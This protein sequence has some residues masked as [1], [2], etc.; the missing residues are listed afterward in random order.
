MTENEIRENYGN[1]RRLIIS[2]RAWNDDELEVLD[3]RLGLHNF[4]FAHIQDEKMSLY[5]LFHQV[6]FKE[7]RDPD[8]EADF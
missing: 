8:D 3:R 1:S 5:D 2:D 7:N 6:A 4:T